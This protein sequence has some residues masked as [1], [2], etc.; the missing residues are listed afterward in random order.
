MKLLD[1]RAEVTT[2][3]IQIKTPTPLKTLGWSKKSPIL[4]TSSNEEK[5]NTI[6]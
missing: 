3:F 6:T 1:I 4:S 5:S 2:A